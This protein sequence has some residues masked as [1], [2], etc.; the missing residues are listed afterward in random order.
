MPID[1]RVDA[2]ETGF[3]ILSC[4][5]L[6]FIIAPLLVL[7]IKRI[8]IYQPLILGIVALIVSRL[9]IYGMQLQISNG[10]P[11]SGKEAGQWFIPIW[12]GISVCLLCLLLACPIFV[13]RYFNRIK[14]KQDN[15]S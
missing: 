15:A 8:W 1:L 6:I 12:I 3:N 14:L 11:D 13:I 10:N 9:G 4:I 2:F 5:S 7:I